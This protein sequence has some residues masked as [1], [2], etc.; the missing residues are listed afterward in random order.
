MPDLL[1]LLTSY[2]LTDHKMNYKVYRIISLLLITCS[3]LIHAAEPNFNSDESDEDSFI[4]D[5]KMT[6]GLVNSTPV[7]FGE[8][9]INVEDALALGFDLEYKGFFLTT[10]NNNRT[11]GIFGRPYLGYHLWEGE[12]QSVDIIGT[13]YIPPINQRDKNEDS[14]A[15][16][17]KL[18]KRKPSLDFGA[19]YSLF[20]DEWYFSSE[21]GYDII[22]NA[23]QSFIADFYLGQTRNAGNWDLIYGTGITWISAKTSNYY[24]GLT[25]DEITNNWHPYKSKSSYTLNFEFSARYP[26]SSHWIFESGINYIHFSK[27]ITQS[28]LVVKNE[29]TTAFIGLGYV[30]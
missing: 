18:S 27:H 16:L 25:P 17:K 29:V 1:L 22:G 28:P 19:R 11:G 5:I 12:Y 14:I 4:Y 24:F 7:Y 13:G 23:H 26:L 10:I 21:L 15:E 9:A 6:Y 8:Q 30:F 2:F 3:G 20:N